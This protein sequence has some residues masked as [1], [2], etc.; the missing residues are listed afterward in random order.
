MNPTTSV[1]VIENMT[2]LLGLFFCKCIINLTTGDYASW[3]EQSPQNVS[4]ANL[5]TRSK[6]TKFHNGAL[7]SAVQFRPSAE[8]LPQNTQAVRTGALS[9]LC[10]L[11]QL[12]RPAPYTSGGSR[13]S[14]PL[15]GSQVRNFLAAASSTAALL[16]APSRN[17]ILSWQAE[18]QKFLKASTSAASS[19]VL[20]LHRQPN[21]SR[22]PSPFQSVLCLQCPGCRLNL[23]LTSVPSLSLRS[24]AVLC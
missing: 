10:R 20:T 5:N 18:G 8:E 2:I 13:S 9:A 1:F 15:S 7:L 14:A 3:T 23:A 6:T 19:K 4:K 11:H 17:L 22:F 12:P 16:P 24:R 21:A